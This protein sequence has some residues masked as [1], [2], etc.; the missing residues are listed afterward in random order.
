M[1]K[2]VFAILMFFVSLVQAADNPLGPGDMIR[3]SIYGNP[4]LTT[5]T[6]VTSAGAVSLPLVGDVQV[7]G[8]SVAQA[9]KNIG[10]L[11]EKGGFIKK[12]QVN[13]VVLQISSQQISV[14]GEVYKPGRFPIERPST[15]T[16]LLA[17]AGG[18]NL[19]G[20][21][22]VTVISQKEGNTVRQEHN[23]RELLRSQEGKDIPLAAGDIIYVPRA[24]MF[25]IYG[26]VQRPGSF[27][28]ER[29]MTVA[30][31]LATGGGLTPRGTE[32]GLVI[33]RKNEK[34]ELEEVEVEPST[35]VQVDDVIQVQERWF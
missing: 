7:G 11:L 3:V 34:G 19:N 26:E 35:L 15:L 23:W 1:K 27:R 32:N 21:D 8:I 4:D 24:Q 29:N 28:L 6:R 14:L 10:N 18:A 31:A 9:E 16:E 30:Q 33:K 25:Y 2:F 5:E 22:F 20:S 12:P 17:M 13:I